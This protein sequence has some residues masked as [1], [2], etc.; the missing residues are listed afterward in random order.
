V[1]FVYVGCRAIIGGLSGGKESGQIPHFQ[2]AA[3]R[4]LRVILLLVALV[5]LSIVDFLLL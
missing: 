3:H 4:L 2:C 1:I 5:A